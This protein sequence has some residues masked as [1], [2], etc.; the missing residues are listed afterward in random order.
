MTIEEKK[1]L[2][3]SDTLFMSLRRLTKARNQFVKEILKLFR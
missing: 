3:K 2:I 1:Y